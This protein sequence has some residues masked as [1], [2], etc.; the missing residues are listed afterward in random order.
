MKMIATVRGGGEPGRILRVAHRRVEIDDRIEASASADPA[1]DRLAVGF[2]VGAPVEPRPGVRRYRRAD[3]AD[4]VGLG[5][6]DDLFVGGDNI[7]SR[8][9]FGTLLA[10]LEAG[11]DVV[12]PFEYDQPTNAWRGED[13]ALEARERVRTQTIPQQPV[14]P[15][16]L[17]EHSAA[18]RPRPRLEAAD[19]TVGPAVV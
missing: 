7:G 5:P 3:N 15:D 11:A 17:V 4:A 1:I 16:A 6:S 13:V 18:G 9:V 12:D 8:G 2:A 19:Q 10:R 14:A